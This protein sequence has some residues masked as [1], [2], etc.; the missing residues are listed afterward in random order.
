MQHYDYLIVG[1]DYS[2]LYL[3]TKP[4]NKAKNA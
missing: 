3:P 1:A 4:N 2:V